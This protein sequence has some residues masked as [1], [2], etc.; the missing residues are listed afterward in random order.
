MKRTPITAPL[1]QLPEAVLP[2]AEGAVIYDSSCSPEA[3]VLF[4]DKGPGYFL[5]SAPKGTLKTEAEL[6][7]WFCR[8]DLAPEVLV[9]ESTDRDWMLTCSAVG[10]DCIHPEYLADPTRLC[11]TTARLLRQLH[12]TD[13]SGCPVPDRT[14]VYQATAE[15]NY[16]LG[17]YDL[18]LFP[19]NWG[20][21]SPEEAFA[22]IRQQGHLLQTDTLLHGDYCLPNIMLDN[23]RFSAF[24]DLGNGGVGD[25]HIDVF[26]GAWTL[27]FNLKTE[28]YC[29]RFLDAY[30]RD[31]IDMDMLRL[32]AA[33]EVFG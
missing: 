9:Y 8:K 10:E 25:R 19:D 12:E 33:F 26:W 11:D 22:L 6:T 7:A 30:G 17:H 24:I 20:F 21:S 14:A 1:P 18:S 2:F 32:V 29:S 16:R 15:Q 3:S 28:K 4:L 5:K 27:F 31:R 13:F 23:W